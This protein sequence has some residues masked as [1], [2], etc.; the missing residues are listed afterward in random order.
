MEKY[1]SN[2][3]KKLVN[4][5]CKSCSNE[6]SLSNNGIIN[7][8]ALKEAA[9]EK[10]N[11]NMWIIWKPLLILL[12]ASSLG[13]AITA[14]A[15]EGSALYFLLN[16]LTSLAIVPLSF[17]VSKYILDFVRGKEFDFDKLFD[18]YKSNV[19]NILLL[20]F[21]TTLFISLWSLL[22]IIPGIIAALSYSMCTYIYVDGEHTE[23]MEV[24]NESKRTTY[25]Y[26]WDYFVFILSFILWGLLCLLFIPFIFVIPYV[27][28]ANAMYYDE[29]KKI[30]EME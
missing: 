11:G 27:T 6:F 30:K 17:G 24:M 25:G 19:V 28:V 1:C 20:S 8:K 18:Y 23:P 14:C 5:K 22:F 15:E 29:L 4:K 7:R 2:C 3:G 9:K 21:L 13:G 12:L 16:A 26:K 10:I